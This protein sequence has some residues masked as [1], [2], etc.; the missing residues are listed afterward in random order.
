M[1]TIK[2]LC[3]LAIAIL[4]ALAS[5]LNANDG[6]PKFSW[7]RVP[8]Y[9]HIGIGNVISEEQIKFLAD[10][11][12]L[13]TFSGGVGV[14]DSVE[15]RI[16]ETTRAIKKI[17]PEAKVL[18]YWSPD[19]PKHQWKNSNASF[20]KDG[21]VRPAVKGSTKGEQSFDVSKPAVREWWTDVAKVACTKHSCD[22]VFA[23]GLTAGTPGGP[24]SN[25]FG[26]EKGAE[27]DAGMKTMMKLA[28]KKLGPD[29]ML[30]FNPLHGDDGKHG[31]L[32]A[33]Y[34]PVTDGAM[35]D[36]FDRGANIRR[37]S[38]QY[39]ASTIETMNKASKD[40]KLVIF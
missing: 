15:Q 18:F 35:V 4:V 38:N 37:Q 2:T 33:D 13:I 23:D 3:T 36:D 20:P 21:Y 16:G 9:A 7:E 17:N 27:L 14:K 30:I 11:Y 31:T 1:I 34:L 24:W 5:P 22:G 32:G 6:F 19:I 12:E 10:N 8:K 26:K 40:G 25:L 29:K 39:L 28:R